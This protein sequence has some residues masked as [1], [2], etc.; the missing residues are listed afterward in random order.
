MAL[1]AARALGTLVAELVVRSGQMPSS[2]AAVEG[3]RLGLE[4]RSIKR[5]IA[6]APA[7]DVTRLVT[8]RQELERRRDAAIARALEETHVASD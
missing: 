7:G 8:R 6:A 3:E 1:A 5:Q 2:E 4:V